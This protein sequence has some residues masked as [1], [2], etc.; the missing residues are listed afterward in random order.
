MERSLSRKW[1]GWGERG[2]DLKHQIS[3]IK[4]QRNSKDQIQNT[5]GRPFGI[6]KL[7]ISDLF[8]IW[9]LR[10]EICLGSGSGSTC[11]PC[12]ASWTLAWRTGITVGG[13]ACRAEDA[14]M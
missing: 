14:A 6:L 7:W 3:S 9:C 12:R 8:G 10:F 2:A 4:S 5:G 1:R 11:Q 13:G